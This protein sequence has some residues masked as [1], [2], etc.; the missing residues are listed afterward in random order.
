M[1]AIKQS[2]TQFLPI[3]LLFTAYPLDKPQGETPTASTLIIFPCVLRSVPRRQL[4]KRCCR[5]SNAWVVCAWQHY[6]CDTL[7]LWRGHACWQRLILIQDSDQDPK[8]LVYHLDLQRIETSMHVY[9][10]SLPE[11]PL[12]WRRRYVTQ[13]QALKNQ[14][15][16]MCELQKEKINTKGKRQR[17]KWV[18]QS[19]SAS[20]WHHFSTKRDHALGNMGTG[21][22]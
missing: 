18:R 14:G 5:S 10:V 11:S 17:A 7:C 21:F 8:L 1:V 13:T 2:V 19:G 22:S 20:S 15:P 16:R 6:L 12:C 4:H 3:F 9:L